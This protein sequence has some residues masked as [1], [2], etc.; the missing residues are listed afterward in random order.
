[1]DLKHLLAKITSVLLIVFSLY[2]TLLSLNSIFFIYPRL[3]SNGDQE[4]LL[5]EQGL[6]EKAIIIYLSMLA[7][8]IYGFVLLFKP[9][10]QVKI[11]HIVFGLLIF[12]ASLF[13]VSK[14]PFTTDPVIQFIQG[15][16]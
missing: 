2:Q 8:G 3:N 16:I 12:G 13:F 6:V 14:T 11:L 9:Q 7:T 4:L 1:M 15:L 5:L 10:N